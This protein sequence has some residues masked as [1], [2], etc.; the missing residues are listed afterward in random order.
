MYYVYVIKSLKDNKCYTGCTR[1]IDERLNRHNRGRVKS[2]RNRR[3]F[4]LEH[5]ECFDNLSE[6]RQR[7]SHL[8]KLSKIKFI[9]G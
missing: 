2:T 7:E 3:P 6:A 8:K 9:A 1:N 4:K 5:V